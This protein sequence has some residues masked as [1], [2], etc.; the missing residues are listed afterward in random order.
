LLTG[1][2]K[3]EPTFALLFLLWKGLPKWE[4]SI[5]Y[6]Y[7]LF[8][9]SQRQSSKPGRSWTRSARPSWRRS[10]LRTWSAT[11]TGFP[12]QTRSVR[13]STGSR[14]IQGGP[15]QQVIP[16]SKE[17]LWIVR[18]WNQFLCISVSVRVFEQ[19]FIPKFGTNFYQVLDKSPAK[20]QQII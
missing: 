11:H 7:N 16:S 4:Y 17:N 19:N 12:P 8:F 14:A 13:R 20:K 15:I 10:T 9:S 2:L 6:F 1:T 5:I 18:P 3:I